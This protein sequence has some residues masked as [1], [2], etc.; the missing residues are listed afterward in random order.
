MNVLWPIAVITLKE[1]IRNRAI[2]GIS[3]F[4][5]MLLGLN[6]LVANMA[7]RD[8]GKVAVD[9]ALSTVSFSGLLIVLFVGIN[10]VAKDLDKKTIYM[11]LSKPIS[12]SE[13]IIGKFFGVVFLL[14]SATGFISFFAIACLFVLKTGYANFFLRFSW[15]LVFLG[16]FF[17]M[18]TLILLTALSFLFASF[19]STSFITLVLTTISYLIGRSLGDIK[20]LIETADISGQSVSPLTVK[21][22]QVAY[23]L[24]PNLSFFDIKTQ[25]AHGFPVPFSTVMWTIVYGIVYS[26]LAIT[27]A[28]IIFRKK[29]F[30]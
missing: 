28:S 1:G 20:A 8:V 12:R 16:I 23:Y 19:S 4:A 7:P 30:P 3:L 11:V 18:I 9:M 6:L 15:P 22:I 27:A 21:V 2:Y 29:E 26:T 24:F 17:I 13:Y 25:V 10:L 14:L 5:L